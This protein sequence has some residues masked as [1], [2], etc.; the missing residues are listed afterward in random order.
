MPRPENY[1]K[2][3][4]LICALNEEENLP[5]VL[6]KIPAWVDEI[7]LVDGHS[8]DNTVELAQKLCPRI[9]LLHQ[10]GQ[11]KDN[12]MKYGSDQASG[13][14]IITLDADGATNPDDICKFIDPLLEGYDFVKGSR[15]L[16]AR[17]F[18]M[19]WYRHF[20]NWVLSTEI[21]LL[22]GA[23]YTDVCAGYNAFWKKSWDKIKFPYEFGYEPMIII[24][25]QKANLKI[26]E[27][28]SHD[29]GRIHGKS[30]LPCCRQGW[31]AFSAILKERFKK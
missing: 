18:K 8:A 6:P 29:N 27:I 20:G 7:L 31:G 28:A 3:T 2:V 4:A 19:P 9:K 21:N 24:R 13:D 11:G 15:F 22:F 10:P 5:Y 16:K 12:A 30:K 25:A 23:K 26:L 1:P 14:I 17:P